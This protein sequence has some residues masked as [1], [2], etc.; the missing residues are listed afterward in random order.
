MCPCLINCALT[1]LVLGLVLNAT[2]INQLGFIIASTLMFFCTA[3]AFGSRR[4]LHDVAIGLAFAIGWLAAAI[5]TT[6]A[7]WVM[8]LQLARG[9]RRFGEVARFDDRFRRRIWRIVLASV[10]MGVVLWAVSALLTPAF[11]LGGWRWL[12]L[13]GLIASGTLAY[14]LLGQLLGAFRIAEFK[15]AMR[16]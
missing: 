12:A 8:V 5:A 15:A 13:L 4:A 16:R 3:R 6:A 11:G 7:A 9:G 14:F 10:L 1:W 2:L